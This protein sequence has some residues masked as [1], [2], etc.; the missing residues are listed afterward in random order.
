MSIKV[1]MPCKFENMWLKD[2]DFVE[3]VRQWWNWY[4]FLGSLS[5][6]LVHSLK[7]LKMI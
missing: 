1:E 2:E 7:L 4:C 6:I 5:F 3:R